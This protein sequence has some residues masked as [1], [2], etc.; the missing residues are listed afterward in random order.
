MKCLFS[1]CSQ[2]TTMAI[3]QSIEYNIL[4][5]KDEKIK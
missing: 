5:E 2:Q 1:I 3:V 4:L